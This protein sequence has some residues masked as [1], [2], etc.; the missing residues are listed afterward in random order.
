MEE[1]NCSII[2]EVL[3]EKIRSLE[4]EVSLKD[5]EIKNLKEE[6]AELIRQ[7]DALCR[8]EKKNA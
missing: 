8:E 2:L 6:K 1:K 7:R 4:V 5:Y 3:A